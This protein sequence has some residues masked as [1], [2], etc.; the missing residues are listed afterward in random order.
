MGRAALVELAGQSRGLGASLP[1]D[2][3]ASILAACEDVAQAAG[4]LFGLRDAVA[5][6]EAEVIRAVASDF[7]LER[8]AV[9]AEAAPGPKGR[10]VVG[11]IPEFAKGP[12]E[13]LAGAW[14]EHGDVVRLQ[15]GPRTFYLVI[16]PEHLRHVLADNARNYGRAE[17]MSV[18]REFIG[19]G[20]LT[21]DGASC[22]GG[23]AAPSSP[24][25]ITRRWTSS[26]PP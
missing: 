25:S 24:P 16:H 5:A 23:T 10:V 12:L 2:T 22:G 21:T 13:F 18:F 7:Q 15:L 11:S 9:T 26:P 19:D 17:S 8:G 1:D 3:L 6:E 14:H 20:L 4:G